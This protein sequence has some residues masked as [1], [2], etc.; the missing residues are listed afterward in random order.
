MDK[1]KRGDL[2][3]DKEDIKTRWNKYFLVYNIMIA[4]IKKIKES[5]FWRLKVLNQH[6]REWK[7][8]LK[9]CEII[10]LQD[11]TNNRKK[12]KSRRKANNQGN[13]SSN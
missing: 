3:H 11:Q 10:W 13:V 2:V 12:I 9:P 7:L 4:A 5:L 8:E 6:K 1:N